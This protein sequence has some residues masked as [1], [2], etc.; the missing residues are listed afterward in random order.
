[1]SMRK[2]D[3]VKFNMDN[4]EVR[5]EIQ[6]V[7]WDIDLGNS[8]DWVLRTWRPSTTQEQEEWRLSRRAAIEEA[9]ALGED[10]F[11]I[12]FNDAGESRLPPQT[13]LVPMPID[14]EFI[15]ERAR[16]RVRLGWG[17]PTPG[18]TRILNPKTGEHSFVKREM[19][20]VVK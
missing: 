14:G 2:G 18:M 11:H 15:V 7:E 6:R 1:M 4:A 20:E 13:V 3:K 8:P 5:E 17:N 19:L 9:H 12:A 10:T 16:C